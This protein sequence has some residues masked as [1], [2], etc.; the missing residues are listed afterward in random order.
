MTTGLGFEFT[1]SGEVGE[2]TPLQTQRCS[3]GHIRA[4]HESQQCLVD[5]C[6]ADCDLVAIDDAQE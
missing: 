5:G 4:H 1:A 6:D 2:G 3:C